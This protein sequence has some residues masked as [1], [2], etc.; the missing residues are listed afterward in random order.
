M[1]AADSALIRRL[2]AAIA[3]G[4]TT[5]ALFSAVV[6]ISEPNRSEL[7]A[8][9]AARQATQA[10]AQAERSQLTSVAAA[11]PAQGVR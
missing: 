7:V 11:L 5:I 3:A 2:A 8:V 9:N 1:K 10:K 4:T 6:A